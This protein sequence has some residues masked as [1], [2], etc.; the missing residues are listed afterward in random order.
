MTDG[1]RAQQFWSVLAFAAR[2]QKLVSYKMLWQLTGMAKVGV[3]GPLGH[4]SAY[5]LRDRTKPQLNLIAVSEDGG[6]PE[7]EFLKDV[8]LAI[9]QPRV[10]VYDWFSHGAPTV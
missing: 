4:I 6:K 1:Q 8:D 3:G 5:C 9:E 2:E 10:F 7:A